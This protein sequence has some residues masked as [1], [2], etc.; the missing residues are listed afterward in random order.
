MADTN[1]RD[2]R[3]YLRRL[4]NPT[5][6]KFLHLSGSGE[7]DGTALAWAGTREQARRL[8]AQRYQD[9][10][11][12]YVLVPLNTEKAKVNDAEHI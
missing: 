3:P 12:P 8:R 10:H 4:M 2:M 5:T 9:Q 11:F 6:H 1:L 7:T